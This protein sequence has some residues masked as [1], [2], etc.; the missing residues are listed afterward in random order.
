MANHASAA[1]RNRQT[2]KRTERN[3]ALR[4][5]L[6]TSVKKA[7]SA[8]EAGQAA[9]AKPLVLAASSF[10]ARAASKGII[11]LKNASRTTSRL[12]AHLAKLG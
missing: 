5:A 9:E 7:R 12:Q 6:R 1:K 2:I 8:L 4:S 10:L 3:K 11:H